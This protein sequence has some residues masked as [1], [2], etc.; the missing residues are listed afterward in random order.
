[1]DL[2]GEQRAKG[3]YQESA[4]TGEFWRCTLIESRTRLRAARGIAKSE[5]EAAIEA[6]ERL[7]SRVEDTHILRRQ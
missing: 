2:R 4:D 3:G 1:V 5:T 7:K 6:F